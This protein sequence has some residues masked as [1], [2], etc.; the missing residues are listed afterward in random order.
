MK[1]IKRRLGVAKGWG[2]RDDKAVARGVG[3]Q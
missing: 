2:Q 3:G 1:A